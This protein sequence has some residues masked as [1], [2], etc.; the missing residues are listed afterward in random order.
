MPKSR[1]SPAICSPSSSLAMNFSRS[2]IGLHTF[3]GILRSP[4]KA[5]LCNPCLR[6]EMS[7][8]S[9]EGQPVK[10]GAYRTFRIFILTAPRVARSKKEG[11]ISKNEQRRLASGSQS[12]QHLSAVVLMCFSTSTSPTSK[13]AIA[14][15]SDV[16]SYDGKRTE[17]SCWMSS[18]RIECWGASSIAFVIW[19][20]SAKTSVAERLARRAS[21]QRHW[22][23][24]PS[25]LAVF[26]TISLTVVDCCPG[27]SGEELNI[28]STHPR[29]NVS[30]FHTT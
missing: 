11:W 2:P 27:R 29:R 3:Q 15:A 13:R 5:Q 10:S 4:Q 30:T 19:R 8:L 24:R 17:R 6:N 22:M 7:P 14:C 12:A 26:Q 28:R 18:A 21:Q 9:Q 23:V 25:A 1:H 20:K 16:D